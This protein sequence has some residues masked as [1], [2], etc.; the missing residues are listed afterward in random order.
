MCRN[1]RCGHA[2][3]IECGVTSLIV[4]IIFYKR[5]KKRRK[6]AEGAE[7]LRV[8]ASKDRAKLEIDPKIKILKLCQNKAYHK[9]D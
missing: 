9:P 5:G 3:A 6:T 2:R 7:D 1:K 8:T 4:E